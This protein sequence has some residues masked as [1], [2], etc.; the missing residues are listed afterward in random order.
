[1]RVPRA[2]IA[3]GVTE[4]DDEADADEDDE[5]APDKD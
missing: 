1:M 5:A 3:S 4:L 2:V